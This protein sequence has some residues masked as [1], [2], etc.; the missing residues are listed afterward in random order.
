MNSQ[1]V[2]I[3]NSRFAGFCLAALILCSVALAIATLAFK[4]GDH[5]DSVFDVPYFVGPT[6]QSFLAGHGLDVCSEGM[7][8]EGNPI[9]FHSARMPVGTLTLAAAVKLFGDHINPVVMFKS[10]ICLIPLWGVMAIVL[11]R[12]GQTRA[13][14]IVC[15]LLLLAPLLMPLYFNSVLNLG[16]EEGY[17]LGF[18]A[19]AVALLLFPWSSSIL[20]RSVLASLTLAAFYLTKSSMLPAALVLLAGL[21]AKAPNWR[22][23]SLIVV[24]FALAPASWALIQHNAG[25]RYTLGTSLDGINFHKGNNASFLDRY[26][27]PGDTNLDQFDNELNKGQSFKDEWSFNDFHLKAGFAFALEN[28]RATLQGIARKIAVMFFSLNH[29]GGSTYG[30]FFE[31]IVFLNMIVFRFLLWGAIGIGVFAAATNK[32][33]G[34]INAIIFLLFVLAYAAPYVAG[35]AYT[36]HAMIL[37]YPAVVLICRSL[38]SENRSTA[39]RR[40]PA[41]MGIPSKVLP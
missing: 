4:Y 40:T 21:M 33:I 29:Y 24:L 31:R 3:D 14:L 19:L 20:A 11:R 34:R 6:V 1:S 18:V 10:L 36:R 5:T 13:Y 9:C 23:R 32:S 15:S 8:T 25:G 41:A 7:G 22:I 27:P 16:V 2:V 17:M 39:P 38:L 28:T 30:Q 12:P 35:F 37:V 26:P